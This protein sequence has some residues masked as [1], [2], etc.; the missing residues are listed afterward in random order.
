M[1]AQ[2]GGLKTKK[3][4]CGLFSHRPGQT[5]TSAA[6]AVKQSKWNH[7]KTQNAESAK[8]AQRHR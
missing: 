5:S 7:S 6:A 2:K 8:W 4:Q 3:T 1:F